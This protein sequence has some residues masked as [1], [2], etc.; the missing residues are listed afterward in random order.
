MSKEHFNTSSEADFWKTAAER[1]RIYIARGDGEPYPW[2]EDP[3]FH[4]FKFTNVFR[5]L[6]A[7]TGA[8]RSMLPENTTDPATIIANVVWY[9]MLNRSEHVDDIGLQRNGD[10]L[11]ELLVRKKVSGAKIFTG[12]HMHSGDLTGNSATFRAI[13]REAAELAEIC[14]M[15]QSL[16]SIFGHLTKTYNHVGPFIGYEI[17][18]DLRHYAA[19]WP[20]NHPVDYNTWANVGPGSRRG[21]ERLGLPPTL[22][23]MRDLLAN[24]KTATYGTVLEPHINGTVSGAMPRFELREIEHW[25]CEFDKYERARTGQGVPKQIYRPKPQK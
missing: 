4:K 8:L 11:T 19:L 25:L 18:T 12:C 16:E 15:S 20:G 17:V 3:I 7:G 10:E 14:E 24:G 9:R 6:D 2:T 13:F 1:H 5:E 21:M 22:Q 23:S